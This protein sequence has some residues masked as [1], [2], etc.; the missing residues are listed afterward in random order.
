MAVDT[1]DDGDDSKVCENAVRVRRLRQQCSQ[2]S[3]KVPRQTSHDADVSEYAF[4]LADD[5]QKV[6]N[7]RDET[8]LSRRVDGV[9]NVCINSQSSSRRLPTD[10]A[11]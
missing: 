11:M 5:I 8:V 1:D 10:S 9:Y 3:I 2:L 7:R 6:R 4:I